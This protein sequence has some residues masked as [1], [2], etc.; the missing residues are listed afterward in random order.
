MYVQ[1]LSL[2][3]RM[4]LHMQYLLKGIHSAS[5]IVVVQVTK[6]GEQQTVL[7]HVSSYF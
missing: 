6:V 1:A 4:Y 7:N 2:Y 5:Y 3:A